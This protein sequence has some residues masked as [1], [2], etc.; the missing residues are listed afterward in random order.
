MGVPRFFRWISERYP[1]CNSVITDLTLMPVFDNLY[2][3]MNGIIHQCSH[4]DDNAPSP[5]ER[6]MLLSIFAYI[7][8]IVKQIVRP[9]KV[10]YIAVDGVAPRAKLNQQRSRRFAAAKEASS[11]GGGEEDVDGFDRNCIT[12]GTS[13]MVSGRAENH[14][15]PSLSISQARIGDK[16][17]GFIRWKIGQ[18][19]A[20]S[21]LKVVYSGA[22][23]PGEGEHKIM[24]YI[25]ANRETV[26]FASN[27]KKERRSCRW[28][29]EQKQQRRHPT[30]PPLDT[31]CTETM[32]T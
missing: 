22:N 29:G 17:R 21:H 23:V 1:K 3:D 30:P 31:A 28:R 12:P 24:Q 11:S 19:P 16:L 25:R 7:D 10:L 6:D 15:R 18:D 32:L 9:Q 8:R 2:L 20:W 14:C 5:S 26:C 27:S 4:P 13:F